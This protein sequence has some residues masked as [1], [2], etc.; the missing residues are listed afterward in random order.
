MLPLC[1]HRDLFLGCTRAKSGL[2][3]RHTLLF[4]DEAQSTSRRLW[5]A[6]RPFEA[7]HV[8]PTRVTAFSLFSVSLKV[9]AQHRLMAEQWWKLIH[10]AIIFHQGL[11]IPSYSAFGQTENNTEALKL[12]S[13]KCWRPE[14]S[15]KASK[16]FASVNLSHP[17]D[18][19]RKDQSAERGY[20]QWLLLDTN[21]RKTKERMRQTAHQSCNCK[22]ITSYC[23]QRKPTSTC[24]RGW[25]VCSLQ[26]LPSRDS[27]WLPPAETH[28]FWKRTNCV[29]AKH[30]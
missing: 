16:Q 22:K 18:Q 10:T 9:Q 24:D 23:T 29:S 30:C 20:K 15:C 28:V 21:K 7:S 1:I 2:W 5:S 13:Q 11:M 4:D 3:I 19:T 6:L 25:L 12:L 27:L 14:K 17:I 26:T 8:F